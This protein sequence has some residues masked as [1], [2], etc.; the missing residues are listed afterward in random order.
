MN[1]Q[2]IISWSLVIIFTILNW[3]LIKNSRVET[4]RG[5]DERGKYNGNNDVVFVNENG[6]CLPV[7]STGIPWVLSLVWALTVTF[8]LTSLIE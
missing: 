1:I 4:I 3:W 5:K 6:N 2:V 7:L 8:P